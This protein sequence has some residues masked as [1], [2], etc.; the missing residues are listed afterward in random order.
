MK[1][2]ICFLYDKFYEAEETFFKAL[3]LKG[4]KNFSIYLRLGFIYLKRKSWGDAKAIF[5]KACEIKTNSPL[6]WLGLGIS[7]FRSGDFKE[8]E[9]ALTQANIYDPFNYSTWSYLALLC[10]KDGH[11]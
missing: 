3:K 10:L 7:S 5:A 8:A 6:A 1:A 2:N 9:E 4:Q 11:R